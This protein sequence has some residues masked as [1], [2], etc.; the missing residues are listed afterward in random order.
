MVDVSTS[1]I[2]NCPLKVV[3]TY[4]ANPDN[5]PEWYVNIQSAVWKT[6]RPLSIGSQIDFVAHFMRRKLSYTY[7][8]VEMTDKKF[9]MKTAQG[10]FPMQTSYEWEA[11]DADHTKMIL[12]NTGYQT[13]FSKIYAP[14]MA[15]MMRR[16]NR[17]D[18]QRLK[19][20]LER[21]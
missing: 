21:H 17:K 12:N 19:Q 8:V 5:A 4:A 9:V 20:I 7:E 3:S 1:I 11:L 10:P 15:M 16:A 6:E 18:L 13:G 14:F 2:I